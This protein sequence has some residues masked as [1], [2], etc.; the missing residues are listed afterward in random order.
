MKKNKKQNKKNKHISIDEKN[1]DTSIDI[2]QLN[3]QLGETK[4]DLDFIANIKKIIQC[5]QSIQISSQAIMGEVLVNN[6]NNDIQKY[7]NKIVAFDNIDDEKD[8]Y[9][10]DAIKFAKEHN[11]EPLAY[12]VERK[13]KKKN[14][15][16]NNAK[17]KMNNIDKYVEAINKDYN[18]I[19]KIAKQV[20]PVLDKMELAFLSQNFKKT[21]KEPAKKEISEIGTQTDN[22]PMFNIKGIVEEKKE[23]ISSIVQG[24]GGNWNSIDTFTHCFD[25]KKQYNIKNGKVE[26]KNLKD[27]RD[28]ADIYFS[29][30]K[31]GFND[32][33][34]ESKFSVGNGFQELCNIYYGENIKYQTSI[35]I[36]S[37]T[38]LMNKINK[39]DE[40]VKTLKE[41]LNIT[42]KEIEKD[43]ENIK[44]LKQNKRNLTRIV[45]NIELSN[46]NL[47]KKQNNK[48]DSYKRPDINLPHI[49]SKKKQKYI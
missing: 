22:D 33:N 9:K 7:N 17:Q 29:L 39:D 14:K 41:M 49:Y 24:G 38:K 13:S 28:F 1:I 21:E 6:I 15:K 10:D 47:F 20:V 4:I 45:S 27:L 16:M 2:N 31:A 19:D 36:G 8:D 34:E 25:K 46:N 35:Q 32:K 18:E 40:K 43:A 5:A 30:I 26:G 11:I 48:I 23:K 3:S 12:L 42:D 44:K 37:I